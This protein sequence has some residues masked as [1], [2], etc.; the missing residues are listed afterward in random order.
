MFLLSQIVGE[1]IPNAAAIALNGKNVVH[2]IIRI[3]ETFGAADQVVHDRGGP[4]Y[5][6]DCVRSRC[7]VVE[8]AR[9]DLS[10]FVD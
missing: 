6:V 8:R 7:P 5:V 2:R 4:V 10:R 1:R 9:G 3:T